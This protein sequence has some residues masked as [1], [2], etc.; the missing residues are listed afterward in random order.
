MA[1]DAHRACAGWLAVAWLAAGAPALAE[2]EPDHARGAALF[3]SYCAV[4]HGPEGRGDGAIAR[5]LDPRPRDFTAGM[6]RLRSTPSGELPTDQDLLRT[7]SHGI[8]GT[9]MPGWAGMPE[10]DLRALIVHLRALS[11]RFAEEEPAAP[12]DVPTAS[13]T[14]SASVPRGRALYAAM[15]CDRCHGPGGRGDGPAA[16]ELVDSTGLPI[17]PFDLTR[18]WKL[19][20]GRS[21][22]DLFRTLRTGLDGTPMPS[23]ADS[24]SPE[25]TWALAD[26]LA[27]LFLDGP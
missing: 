10:A 22:A 1:T 12:I 7:L 25:E 20:N 2:A 24:L 16:R 21:R 9:A 23:Y 26:F 15:Q 27:T 17:A 14:S 8:P 5:G 6:Y 18:S 4:C 3:R 13:I 11:P 19:K